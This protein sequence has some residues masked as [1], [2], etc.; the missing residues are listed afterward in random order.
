M[1]RQV[2]LDINS[3]LNATPLQQLYGTNLYFYG[4]WGRIEFPPQN[5]DKTHTL[6]KRDIINWPGLSQDKYKNPNQ[7][8]VIWVANN[9][10]DP[11]SVTP[12]TRIRIPSTTH[13]D[14]VMTSIT[15]DAE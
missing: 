13:V 15:R 8:W 4:V 9:I 14:R 12:G 7:A 10:S 3:R 11:W 5:D 2:E 6:T 1:A